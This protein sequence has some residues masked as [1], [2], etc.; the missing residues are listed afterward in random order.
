MQINVPI[1]N[2]PQLVDFI[3]ENSDVKNNYNLL[4]DVYTV[5]ATLKCC[6]TLSRKT[7]DTR[8]F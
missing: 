4:T 2:H 6:L 5:K 8:T 3:V 7:E 1:K